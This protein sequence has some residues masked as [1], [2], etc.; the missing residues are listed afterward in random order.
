MMHNDLLGGELVPRVLFLVLLS[1]ILRDSGGL[2]VE[3]CVKV[4]ISVNISGEAAA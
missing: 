1:S 4:R 2:M 3:G